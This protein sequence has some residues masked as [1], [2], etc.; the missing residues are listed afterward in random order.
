MIE[1]RECG[2][3]RLQMSQIS[4]SFPGEIKG[5]FRAKIASPLKLLRVHQKEHKR[6]GQRDCRQMRR[7]TTKILVTVYVTESYFC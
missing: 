7:K 3:Y 5:T 6:S 4:T 2:L 1:K